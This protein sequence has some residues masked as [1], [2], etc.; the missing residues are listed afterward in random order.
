M[1]FTAFISDNPA[2]KTDLTF[3]R[4]LAL[5]YRLISYS[6]LQYLDWNITKATKKYCNLCNEC[7]VN[8]KTFAINFLLHSK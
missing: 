5:N 6:S 4:C 8:V 3:D 1:R 7:K 2:L